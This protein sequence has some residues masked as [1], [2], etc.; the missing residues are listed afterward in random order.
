MSH[1]FAAFTAAMSDE[2]TFGNGDTPTISE[3]GASSPAGCQK[4]TGSG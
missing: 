4:R 1:R 3:S 2:S